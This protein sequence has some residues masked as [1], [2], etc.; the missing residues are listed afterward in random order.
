MYCLKDGSELTV[1]P[2]QVR[3][4]AAGTNMEAATYPRKAIDRGDKNIYWEYFRT[5]NLKPENLKIMEEIF[6][7]EVAKLKSHQKK[8]QTATR[9]QKL[10]KKT[11]L[12]G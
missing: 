8:I 12:A 5:I 3:I 9:Q 1:D 10:H 11:A 6:K 7:S 2:N 4:N